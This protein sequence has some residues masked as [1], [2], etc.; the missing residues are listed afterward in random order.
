MDV[1]AGT[2]LSFNVDANFRVDDF[3]GKKFL[4]IST[5]S[6]LGGKNPF[7]GYAYI[8]VGALALLLAL[9]F[10][11]KQLISPRELGDTKYLVWK[12]K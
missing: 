6:A 10:L 5:A 3:K 4:V 9:V 11:L 7:L 2:E 1:E 12:Q 8:G